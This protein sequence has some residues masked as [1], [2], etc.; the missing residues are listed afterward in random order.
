MVE[1]YPNCLNYRDDHNATPFLTACGF[2]CVQLAETLIS[3]YSADIQGESLYVMYLI[4]ATEYIPFCVCNIF[5]HRVLDNEE[6][7]VVGKYN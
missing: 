3:D 2:G 5:L 6:V 1:R 7:F 4:E